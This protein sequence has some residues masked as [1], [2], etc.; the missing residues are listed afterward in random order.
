M[1]TTMSDVA[2]Q[3]GVSVTTVSHVINST[4]PV[5]ADLRERVVVAMAALNYQP[6]RLARSLRQGRT[7]TIGMIVPDNA[8]PYFAEVARGIEETAYQND[9]SLILCNSAGDLD[10][11]RFYINVLLEKQVD[12]IILV[13]AGSSTSNIANI[14][15]PPMVV[16]DRD[17][18]NIHADAV[19]TENAQG[20]QLATEHLLALGHRRIACITG[21]SDVTP[22]A[23]RATGYRQALVAAGVEV[24]ENLVVK[25]DFHYA[26][27]YAAAKGL[28]TGPNPPTAIFAC[29]DLM[30]VGA[31]SAG[32]ELGL[33]IPADLSIVGFDDVQLAS[34][35]N[36]PLT[37]V[38]QPKREMGTLAVSLLLERMADPDIP[39]RRRWLGT[40]LVVR[41]STKEC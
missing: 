34:F 9:Y 4:R 40:G 38:A 20:G 37:T 2:A 25:G 17:L 10:R 28:L 1:S 14:A 7:H 21:A 27:G 12:G 39:P 36:P 35:T 5:S 41:G 6:N 11:E 18:P 32:I 16:V 23:E 29:N 8:N 33:R 15:L 3:A 31:I 26:S 13:A 22:T 30:A 19:L 24:D